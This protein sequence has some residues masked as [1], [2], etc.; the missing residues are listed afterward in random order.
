MIIS[1]VRIATESEE[2]AVIDAIKLVADP[3]TGW[4]WLHQQKMLLC[5][6]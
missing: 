4:V 5:K 2:G 1:P 6:N 3:F